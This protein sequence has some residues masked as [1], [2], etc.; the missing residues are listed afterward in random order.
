[1]PA[2]DNSP[3][4]RSN[5]GAWFHTT[6]WQVVLSARDG[7]SPESQE[8]LERLCATYWYPLYAFVRQEGYDA[9]EAE[10]LTQGFFAVLLEK[11]YL[12][13][14]DRAKG[15]FRS[16]LLSSLRHFLC[17]EYERARTRKRGGD[18]IQV[19]WDAQT[20][21]EQ[22]RLESV[23]LTTPDL[24]FDRRWALTVLATAT[25]RL[26]AEYRAGGKG[27]LYRLHNQSGT[28]HA[29]MQAEVAQ[30]MGLPESTIK[31]AAHRMRQ[32]FHDLVRQEIASTVATRSEV[33]EEI[34]YLLKLV[35]RA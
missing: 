17:N 8:A 33:D 22:Y 12:A 19:S 4:S 5:Q 20:A 3:D 28:G 30:Q 27:K 11:N 25:A 34:R 16:F 15:K 13:Q 10:D 1:M 32:R 6:L 29:M 18:R 7:D 26:E 31:S 21:E 24:L 35:T 9:H 2:R 14:V 23:D